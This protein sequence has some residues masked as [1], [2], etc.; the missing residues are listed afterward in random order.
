MLAAEVEVWLEALRKSV[1]ETLH[2]MTIAVISDCH[3]GLGL[4][5]WAL[6]VRIFN[7]V[8]YL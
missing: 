3:N 7:I 5:D 8:I 6:K 2:S 4:E 1:E